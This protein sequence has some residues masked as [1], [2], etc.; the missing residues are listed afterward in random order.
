M[1]WQALGNTL[2]G[3]GVWNW[4]LARHPAATVTPMAL[5]VPVFGMAASALS[6]GE[7]LPAWK[8]GAGASP[9]PHPF[10]DHAQRA[11]L[12][13]MVSQALL[14]GAKCARGVTDANVRIQRAPWAIRLSDKL[15]RPGR[16]GIYDQFKLSLR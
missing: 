14:S 6:L 15:N 7:P 3:Y 12:G 11:S 5:L 4:L 9:P 1:L 8:L 16:A 2:F 13:Q 10:V